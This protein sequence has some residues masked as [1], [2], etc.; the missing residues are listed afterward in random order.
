MK[1]TL[2]TA[3]VCFCALA[4][5]VGV[6]SCSS[7]SSSSEGEAEDS[8]EAGE[9]DTTTGTGSTSDGSSSDESTQTTQG[10]I[11]DTPEGYAGATWELDAEELTAVTVST[12][13]DL[14]S[15][16]KKGGY[17]IWV[18]GMIDMSEGY[19]PEDNSDEAGN[20]SSFIKTYTD[21]SYTTWTDW[22]TAYAAACTTSSDDETGDDTLDGYQ[23]DM[24]AAWKALIKLTVKSNTMIIG[25]DTDSCIKGGMISISGESDIA[26]RNLVIE[27]AFDPFPHH[28]KND[29]YNAEYDGICIQGDSSNIWVDHCTLKDTMSLA[30]VMTGGDD[31]TSEKWQTYDGLLDIKGTG[32]NISVSYC[33]F[34]DHD[35]TSLIG[36]SDSEGDASTRLITYHHNYFYNCGQ[37]L[38]MVRNTT[39]HLYNNYFD[40]SDPTYTQQ[41]AVGVRAGSTVYSENNYFG[42]GIKYSFN[43]QS[44][45]AGTL[46]SSGDSDNSSKGVNTKYV[47]SSGESL[48]SSSVG[49]YSYTAESASDAKTTVTTYAGATLVFSE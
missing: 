43:A 37:R 32:A 33:K 4:F 41:Y 40:A 2:F 42:S 16:A 22:R 28:E 18:D 47:E 17:L 21:G 38:P 11:T 9:G 6:M 13:S 44:S 49:T 24:V 26:I 27:D 30:Y 36:S 3:G 5:L 10:S 1:K 14:V 45:S 12:K 20:L 48:F 29:G 46:Y 35:K 23:D 15:Y 19:L 25:K 7:D 31:G 34:Q 8:E 39:F